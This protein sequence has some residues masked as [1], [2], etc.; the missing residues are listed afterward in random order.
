MAKAQGADLS[1]LSEELRQLMELKDKSQDSKL[2]EFRQRNTALFAAVQ[3]RFDAS[4]LS[5]TLATRYAL[6][7]KQ[8][9]RRGE[10]GGMTVDDESTPPPP[11]PNAERRLLAPFTFSGT[12]QREDCWASDQGGVSIDNKLS[13]AGSIQRTA[14]VGQALVVPAGVRTVE[15]LSIISNASFTTRIGA[16][17]GYASSESLLCLRLLTENNALLAEDRR[18]VLHRVIPILGV[19]EG[20]AT[21]MFSLLVRYTRT[22]PTVEERLHI[23]MT[24]ECWAGG[25]GVA[26]GYVKGTSRGTLERLDIR[27]T[28]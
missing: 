6:G 11:A 24:L 2:A 4:G 1:K 17:Y 25:G 22:N 5:N 13:F 19:V 16:I 27:F 15:V 26:G 12:S 9:L 8:T 21:G 23:T 18:S 10:S 7:T 3:S 28:R 20:E 14:F